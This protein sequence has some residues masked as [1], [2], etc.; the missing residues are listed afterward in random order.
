MDLEIKTDTVELDQSMYYMQ[1][2]VKFYF[3]LSFPK[4]IVAINPNNSTSGLN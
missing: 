2:R 1:E 4:V 3:F